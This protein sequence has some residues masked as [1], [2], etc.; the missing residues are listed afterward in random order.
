MKKRSKSEIDDP[1]FKQFFE[2]FLDRGKGCVILHQMRLADNGRIGTGGAYDFLPAVYKE[3][4]AIK[5]EEKP[6]EGD[7]KGSEKTFT[8]PIFQVP[9][10]V[11]LQRMKEI[12]IQKRGIYWHYLQNVDPSI[13]DV[14]L[15]DESDHYS[16]RPLFITTK[17]NNSHRIIISCLNTDWQKHNELFENM[18]SY[19]I[20]G[21]SQTAIIQDTSVNNTSFEFLLTVLQSNNQKFKLYKKEEFQ[22]F[23]KN[24]EQG[25]HQIVFIGPFEESSHSMANEIEDFL[26][27]YSVNGQLKMISVKKGRHQLNEV[28]INGREKTSVSTLHDLELKVQNEIKEEGFIDQSFWNT[29]ESLRAL[30]SMK[31][32]VFSSFFDPLTIETILEHCSSHIYED[33]S[34][35]FAF[36]PTVAFLWLKHTYYGPDHHLTK[37]TMDWIREHLPLEETREKVMALSMFLEIGAG[38]D[39]DRGQLIELISPENQDNLSEIQV[40]Y[41]LRASILL[42]DIECIKFY[43]NWLENLLAENKI[44]KDLSIYATLIELLLDSMEVLQ[45]SE[46]YTEP[47]EEIIEKLMFSFI[48]DIQNAYKLRK[49]EWMYP[50]ENKATTS[51]KCTSALLR[52]EDLLDLPVSEV[53]QSIFKY[54]SNDSSFKTFRHELTAL[55]Q[56]KGE[57]WRLQGNEKELQKEKEELEIQVQEAGKMK[58]EKVFHYTP[59]KMMFAYSLLSLFI[60]GWLTIFIAG[61]EGIRQ[62]FTQFS[63]TYWM[64][65][66]STLTFFATIFPLLQIIFNKKKE[67]SR[68]EELES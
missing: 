1:K 24:I 37:N 34:Y 28:V 4:T 36:S 33:G 63:K 40:S 20:D 46:E 60:I 51:L 18:I 59:Y 14:L 47:V 64:S 42:K 26:T 11:D 15:F 61:N 57:N 2:E 67:N 31:D 12:S 62:D 23:K 49:H 66:I 56:L 38:T 50:W 22:D 29:V 35:D 9:K 30:D 7:M 44:W 43:V 21:K 52:F 68:E 8:H 39:L 54:S 10:T 48:L 53:A 25:N 3:V 5:R 13:W 27:P 16:F 58:F 45:A 6:V 17:D 41:L 32:K 65:I 55:E 19:A